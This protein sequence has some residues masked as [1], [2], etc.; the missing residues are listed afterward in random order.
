MDEEQAVTVEGYAF[1][2]RYDDQEHLEIT[3]DW[4]EHFYRRTV[5]GRINERVSVFDTTA[6][7]LEVYGRRC[8]AFGSVLQWDLV[9]VRTELVPSRV[10]EAL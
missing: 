6:E 4:S 2:D 5:N 1:Q 10:T 9:R 8:V 7:A 3:D